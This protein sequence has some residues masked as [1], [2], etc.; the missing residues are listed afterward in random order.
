[1]VLPQKGTQSELQSVG[2]STP[3]LKRPLPGTQRQPTNAGMRAACSQWGK[4][5][6]QRLKD[7]GTESRVEPSQLLNLVHQERVP[8][9][10]CFPL[11]ERLR[12]APHATIPIPI[13][14]LQ[15]KKTSNERGKQESD[16]LHPCI[17]SPIQ[18]GSSGQGVSFCFCRPCHPQHHH[19][20]LV[21]LE[22]KNQP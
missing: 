17:A 20:H 21:C 15:K 22:S 18:I 4:G 5:S 13:I 7:R 12:R 16:Y 8:P 19:H 9:R 10:E 14:S 3:P 6:F 11:P 1:V 2:H